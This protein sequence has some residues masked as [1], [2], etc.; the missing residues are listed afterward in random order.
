MPSTPPPD[1]DTIDATDP[2]FSGPDVVGVHEARDLLGVSASQF[3][4]LREI[5]P[6]FPLPTIL[7]SGAVWSGEAMRAYNTERR[8]LWGSPPP[9]PE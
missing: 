9:Q 1:G 2:R 6:A 4:R 8:K 3:R 5:D 7:R